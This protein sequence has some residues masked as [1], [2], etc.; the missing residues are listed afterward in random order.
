MQNDVRWLWVVGFLG[1]VGAAEARTPSPPTATTQYDGTYAFVSATK[2]T[3]TYTDYNGR[4][5]PCLG[6][7]N[8]GPLTIANGQTR[9]AGYDSL[10]A[11]GFEG[12]VGSQGELTMHLL[13]TISTGHGITRFITGLIDGTGAVHAR[14]ISFTCRFDLVWQ[15]SK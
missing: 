1:L 13:T 6:L 4:M 10:S 2:V 15:K 3:E 7:T 5:K 12:T 9:L 11:A 14:Q 8:V